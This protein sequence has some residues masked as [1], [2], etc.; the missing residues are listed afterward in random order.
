MKNL[1]KHSIFSHKWFS[2]KKT[3]SGLEMSKFE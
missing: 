3:H 1:F 2:I